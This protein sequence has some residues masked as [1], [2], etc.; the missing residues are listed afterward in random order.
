MSP[1]APLPAA[2]KNVIK[3]P[4]VVFH[5][6]VF[7]CFGSKIPLSSGGKMQG[8]VKTRPIPASLRTSALLRAKCRLRRLRSA[9]RCG[10]RL[11]RQSVTPS[12]L[13]RTLAS[14]TEGGRGYTEV[15]GDLDIRQIIFQCSQTDT[16]SAPSGSAVRPKFRHWFWRWNA[17]APLRRCGCGAAAY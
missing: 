5:R 15:S 9:R 14:L 13:F 2:S 7:V 4:P 16:P 10:A 11:V 1:C 6:W 3:D 12:C 8:R 17:A